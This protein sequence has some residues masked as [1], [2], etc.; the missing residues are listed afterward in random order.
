MW[1]VQLLPGLVLLRDKVDIRTSNLVAFLKR[2]NLMLFYSFS[3]EI[4]KC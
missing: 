2:N 4:Q 1:S 3:K